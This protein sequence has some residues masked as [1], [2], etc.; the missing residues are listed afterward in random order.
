MKNRSLH[1]VMAILVLALAGLLL[2]TGCTSSSPPV[3][4]T[5]TQQVTPQPTSPAALGTTMTTILPT[6]IPSSPLTQEASPL[7]SPGKTVTI[8]NLGFDPIAIT[9]KSGTTVTWTNEDAVPHTIT[10][11]TPSPVAFDSGTLQQGA[12]FTYTFT[13][14]GTY[15]YFCTIH[16]F[17]TG[18]VIVVP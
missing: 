12:T 7:T 14:V 5:P 2:V 3:V 11:K 8:K 17:M 10:S 16:T 15:S 9:V 1:F 6:V 13:Q 4:V 18:T